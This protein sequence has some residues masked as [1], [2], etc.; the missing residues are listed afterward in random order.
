MRFSFTMR[1]FRL[2]SSACFAKTSAFSDATSSVSRSGSCVWLPL[3]AAF[4][5]PL[6]RKRPV[7]T[8]WRKAVSGGYWRHASEP[9]AAARALAAVDRAATAERRIGSDG[10]PTHRVSE[11]SFYQRRKRLA[12]QLPV[13]FALVETNGSEPA[14]AGVEVILT[15]GERLRI[16]PGADAATVRLALAVLREPR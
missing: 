14:A 15:T 16:A 13:K 12:E 1:S 5:S 7:N 3:S 2:S 4:I 11:H 6:C 9:T 10:V 8:T